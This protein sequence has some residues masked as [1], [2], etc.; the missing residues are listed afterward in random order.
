MSGG[1][2]VAGG[3]IP[4]KYKQGTYPK[5]RIIKPPYYKSNF[6]D[7]MHPSTFK[8]NPN[9]SWLE[10]SFEGEGE[11]IQGPSSFGNEENVIQELPSSDIQ[12]AAFNS[13]NNDFTL[14]EDHY[15]YQY[16]NSYGY[17]YSGFQKPLPD[18]TE[19]PQIG[20]TQETSFGYYYIGRKLWYIPLYFSIYFVLYVGALIIKALARHKIRFPENLSNAVISSNN[21]L[22]NNDSDNLLVTMVQT[23]LEKFNH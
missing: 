7:R 13:D 10:T 19:A 16:P 4:N 12:T 17:P 1:M 22:L 15:S 9:V 5:I 20:K 6:K 3:T 2:S 18:I 23:A 11:V 14:S 8:V 21:R